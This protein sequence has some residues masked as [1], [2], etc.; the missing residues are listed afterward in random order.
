MSIVTRTGDGGTTGLMYNR[1]VPKHHPQVEACGAVD[2]LN[3]ALGLARAALRRGA[4][5]TQLRDVQQDLV[6][7]MGELATLRTDRDRYQRDGFTVVGADRIR[8]LDGIAAAVEARVPRRRG[9]ALPGESPVAAAL[10]LARTVC[11]RAERRVCALL[12]A[13]EL[14][15]REV[16]VY[17]NRLADVLWLWARESEE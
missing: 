17:L 3:A 15:N 13:G 2:E 12:D 14:E 4:L 5:R 11:R 8:K 16:G 7:L 10:D 6:V 1:R 9:W